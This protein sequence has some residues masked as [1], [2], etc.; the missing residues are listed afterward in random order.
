MPWHTHP[1]GQTRTK[2]P[3]M[4]RPPPFLCA[5]AVSPPKRRGV[6]VGMGLR[7]LL[8]DPRGEGGLLGALT[9]PRPT[10]QPPHI[11]M[12]FLRQKLK[13]IKGAGNLRPIFGTQTVFW[14][15]TPPPS[16]GGAPKQ[17][18]DGRGRG[19]AEYG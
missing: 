16:P 15:L 3:D 19:R 9:S 11:R 4:R 10:P 12:G 14:P 1:G 17:W 7:P 13:F 5:S 2:P 8:Q 6:G 18:P